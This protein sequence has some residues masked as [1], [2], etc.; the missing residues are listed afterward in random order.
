MESHF[1][2][3]AALLQA[4]EAKDSDKINDVVDTAFVKAPNPSPYVWM[5]FKAKTDG[6]PA[7]G[8]DIAKPQEKK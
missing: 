7:L 6:M 4:L 8:D 2:A 3:M 1:E 5:N